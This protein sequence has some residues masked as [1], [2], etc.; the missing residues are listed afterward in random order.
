MSFNHNN[1][2]QGEVTFIRTETIK[3]VIPCRESK[4][5]FLLLYKAFMKVHLLNFLNFISFLAVDNFSPQF[6]MAKYVWDPGSH[7]HFLMKKMDAQNILT[8]ALY[9]LN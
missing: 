1:D 2:K 6:L 7:K 5:C 8:E 9:I 3:F 4:Y